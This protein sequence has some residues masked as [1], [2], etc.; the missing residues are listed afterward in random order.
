MITFYDFL[1]NLSMSPSK[2][3]RVISVL[4][5]DLTR[6]AF[7]CFVF[8][9]PKRK[10]VIMAPLFLSF[11]QDQSLNYLFEMMPT[12]S[13]SEFMHIAFHKPTCFWSWNA[14]PPFS[15]SKL[16]PL[17]NFNYDLSVKCC[18]DAPNRRSEKAGNNPKLFE[19]SG[20]F[21]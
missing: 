10:R 11:L 14:P 20:C 16:L 15:S 6:F 2:F 13:K 1:F 19:W 7:S 8:P 4:T 5:C 17:I 12:R 3:D 18:T 9:P 21:N